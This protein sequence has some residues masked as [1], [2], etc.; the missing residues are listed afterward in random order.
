MLQFFSTFILSM[1]M[2][3]TCFLLLLNST[4]IQS[5]PFN[6]SRGAIYATSMFFEI[7]GDLSAFEFR[8]CMLLC[9]G[10]AGTGSESGGRCSI[11]VYKQLSEV[12][13]I[14]PLLYVLH[15]YFPYSNHMHVKKKK[16]EPG[17][18]CLNNIK[19]V[20]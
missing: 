10:K 1:Q 15:I 19:C 12:A 2:M 13:P 14:F 11:I 9:H 8:H 4:H 3:K 18:R 7:A 20:L 6:Q 16:S 5:P 17:P